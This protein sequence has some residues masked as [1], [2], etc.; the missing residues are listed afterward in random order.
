MDELQIECLVEHPAMIR[1]GTDHGS[2]GQKSML[3]MRAASP[4][5]KP[6]PVMWE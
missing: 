2:G 4:M 1:S 6:C 3:A 5:A